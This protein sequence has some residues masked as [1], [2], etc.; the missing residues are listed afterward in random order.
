MD[1]NYPI[2]QMQTF[3]FNGNKQA[4][5]GSCFTVLWAIPLLVD[6]QILLYIRKWKTEKIS[7]KSRYHRMR[8]DPTLLCPLITQEQQ[9]VMC[10]HRKTDICKQL[11]NFCF[12]GTLHSPKL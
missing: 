4:R 12:H 11:K 6:P 7:R 5:N 1:Q 2:L 9:I 8:I 3:N 10:R